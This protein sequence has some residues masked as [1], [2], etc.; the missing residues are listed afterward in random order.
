M[1]QKWMQEKAYYLLPVASILLFLGAWTY[2]SGSNGGLIPTP[3]ETFVRFIELLYKPVANGTIFVH[4]Y[5]SLQRVLAAFFLASLF[6]VTLGILLGWNRRFDAFF[7]PIFEILRPIPP[8]AWI[9]LVILWFGIGE[10]PKIVIVFIGSFVPVVLN[11]YSGIK[12]IDPLLISAGRVL[13][14]SDR[15]LLWD[16]A[17]PASLPAILAGMKTALGSGWMCVLAAEMV[18][19][20][21]GVGFLIVRG[22][23]S[24]DSTLIIV[25]M[26][27]IGIVSAL[28]SYSLSKFERVMCPWRS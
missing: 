1:N 10:T 21:Q 4:T 12:M 27:V 9:P 16:V 6:G 25:C 15:Q 14:A 24:G 28:I 18:V 7:G 2:V 23:E 22:M 17:M 11:T 3:K 8:I 26:M 13:G 5:V 19:A 20:K